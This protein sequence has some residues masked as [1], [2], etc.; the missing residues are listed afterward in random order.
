MNTE[1]NAETRLALTMQ[2]KPHCD[3]LAIRSTYRQS[4]ENK[5]I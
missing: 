1:G 4:W 2:S 5:F 3:H